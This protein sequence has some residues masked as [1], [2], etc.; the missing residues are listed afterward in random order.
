[1]NRWTKLRCKNVISVDNINIQKIVENVVIGHEGLV[2][3][4]VQVRCQVRCTCVS[5]EDP[6]CGGGEECKG[7]DFQF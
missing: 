7:K 6:K 4:G 1:M 3:K 5:G 2:K